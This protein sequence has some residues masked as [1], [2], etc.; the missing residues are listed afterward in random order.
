MLGFL[1]APTVQTSILSEFCFCGTPDVSWVD[2]GW[3][4]IVVLQCDAAV[5]T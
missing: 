4:V 2:L 3:G 1:D 5:N